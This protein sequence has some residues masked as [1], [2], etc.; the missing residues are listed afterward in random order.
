MSASVQIWVDFQ[1]KIAALHALVN[2]TTCLRDAL[3]DRNATIADF[4][5]CLK[6]MG[7]DDAFVGSN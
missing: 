1:A 4:T 6:E 3:P 5:S 7:M 2:L